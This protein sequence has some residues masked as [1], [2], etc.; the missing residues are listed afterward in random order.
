MKQVIDWKLYDTED[1][2]CVLSAWFPL[3]YCLKFKYFKESLYK[4][5]EW[6]YFLLVEWHPLSKYGRLISEIEIMSLEDVLN[7]FEKNYNHFWK[8]SID[9]FFKNTLIPMFLSIGTDDT[10]ET[11][12]FNTKIIFY[13]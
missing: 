10:N 13:D 9:N 5:K 6:Q 4:S 1:S 12:P 2:E 8:T 3:D 11:P 7:W